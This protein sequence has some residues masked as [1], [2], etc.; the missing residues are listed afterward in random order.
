MYPVASLLM[1]ALG[2]WSDNLEAM[3]AAPITALLFTLLN[4]PVAVAILWIVFRQWRARSASFRV[5]AAIALALVAHFALIRPL[6]LFRVP[7]AFMAVVVALT[8]LTWAVV[9]TVV[10]RQQ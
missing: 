1:A 2:W 10:R 9:C 5:A 7:D 8:A 3:F 6:Q 4:Y